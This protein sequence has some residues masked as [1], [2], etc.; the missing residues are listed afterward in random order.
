[1]GKEKTK[2]SLI[3]ITY[4]FILLMM[5]VYC[6]QIFAFSGRI[7]GYLSSFL[8]GIMITFILSNPYQKF[9]SFYQK[10]MKMSIRASRKAGMVSTYALVVIIVTALIWIIIPQVGESIHVFTENVD[11]YMNAIQANINLW[12]E[13][14]HIQRLGSSELLE[15]LQKYVGEISKLMP[16]VVPH[17]TN[18]TIS[19]VSA[20]ATVVVGIGFSIYLL[21]GYETI[22]YQLRRLFK[23]IL[24]ERAFQSGEYV[25]QVIVHS[26]N[27]YFVG[28]GTEA[29]ILGSLCFAGMLILRLD[30]AALVSVV[31]AITAFIPILG[32]YIGGG[33]AVVLLLLVSPRKAVLFLI[34][35]LSLQW[36][37]NN[38]I[39]PKVVGKRTG[40]PGIWV[41]L[42]FSVGGKAG[43]IPGMIFAVPTT[44]V[45]YCLLKDFVHSRENKGVTS[46]VQV[47]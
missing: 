17:I 47:E 37:E 19:M 46:K 10:R 14:L 26:F 5:L 45:I 29:I 3:V 38:F 35:F 44:T 25:L 6:R 40:L 41:L 1:M 30:Y 34:F 18:A 16:E 39:Y 28:Q 20:I 22:L 36:V 15:G 23:V 33:L 24:S 2:Q 43:G 8:I 32:S 12:T 7:L 27:N 11:G 9:R 42:A 31:V 4:S 13:R 21:G